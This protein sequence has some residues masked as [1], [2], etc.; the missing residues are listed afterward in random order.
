MKIIEYNHSFAKEVAKMWN[1]SNSSWGN[2]GSLQTEQDIITKE[3]SSG[4]IKLYL[5]VDNN[6]VVGYCSFSEYQQDEGA[7][8][9][10][11]LNVRP[12][13]H[14]KKVGKALILKVLED[15]I[16]ST[17]PRFDLYT[18]SGNIK[19]MP[20]YKKCGFFWEKDNQRVHLMNFIP[21]LYQTE[22]LAKHLNDIDWYTDSKRM[23]DMNQDGLEEH[24]F[25][26]YRYDFENEKT[27]L[28]MEF[29]RYGRGLRMIETPD[30][31]I[32]MSIPQKELVY[33]KS[34]Q[35]EFQIVN[36]TNQPLDITIEPTSNKNITFEGKKT[37]SVINEETVSMEFFVGEIDKPI[38]K[39]KT[40]PVVEANVLINGKKA[41]FKLG[42]EPKCPLEAK[43]II[44]KYNH[45][46]IDEY[47][48][49][50]DLENNLDHAETFTIT[51]PSTIATF[52]DSVTVTLESK[53]KR[54]VEIIYSVEEFGIYKEKAIITFANESIEKELST[55]IKGT[56]S[57]FHGLLE[58]QA[59]LVS[60]NYALQ[61]NLHSHNIR[62]DNSW[63]V[64]GASVFL[65][66]KIGLP[67]SLEFSNTKPLIS[68]PSLNEMTI[69][70]ES[71]AF[72]AVK[73]ILYVKNDY[74]IVTINYK[75]VNEGKQKTLA[76][77]I[78]IWNRMR[79]TY[80]P[81]DGQLLKLDYDGADLSSIYNDKL[82]E[83][84][85]YNHKHNYGLIWHKN[86]VVEIAGWS[87]QAVKEGIVL[88]KGECYKTENFTLSYVHPNLKNFREFIGYY[89]EKDETSFMDINANDGNPFTKE[90]VNISLSNKRKCQLEGTITVDGQTKD[91]TESLRVSPGLK[92]AVIDLKDKQVTYQKM[93]FKLSG[94][95]TQI[96]SDDSLTID[97]GVLSFSVSD[98]YSDAIYSLQ[99][100]SHE[101]LDSNYPTPKE[102]VWWGT[103]IGGLN[104]RVFGVQDN[105]V[106]QEK[107]KSSFVTLTDNFNN[108]WS[109]IKTS[110]VF[111][112]EINLKGFT[113]DTYTLTLPG[114]EL[115]YTFT[116]I[117]N[118]T[119][120][121]QNKGYERFITLQ[122]DDDKTKV[123]FTKDNTTYKCGDIAVEDRFKKHIAL[124]STRNHKLN[125]YNKKNELLMDSQTGYTICFSVHWHEI[126]DQ[127]SKLFS[128][129]FIFFTKESID[130]KA[131]IDLENI[132]F[133][134]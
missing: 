49:Y 109:G 29:E 100:D 69:T 37:V 73:V 19:A 119:G 56:S 117:K 77:K 84:W 113:F 111:E 13:Y 63:D 90:A 123:S 28:S 62:V 108:Q 52:K 70:Y 112:K 103:F 129:D 127:E 130:K 133:E 66:P 61:Y 101:W 27:K 18:W 106:L 104:F 94:D 76:L 21:Y 97:N 38:L 96:K 8:Y 47:K 59:F 121:H 64:Q 23:I 89:N 41:V 81:F 36:K 134:V 20:L 102:R 12:D 43:L 31:K 74:G 54:S 6:E 98:T 50:L 48:A 25:D 82:D 83:N 120:K 118:N 45:N 132:T 15:A 39:S 91:I 24:G 65:P 58:H 10:P 22:A 107:R 95:V 51:L 60:G 14:G 126:P 11:L 68:F 128:G 114:V 4:N 93:L 72:E 80:V 78:P 122:A 7:S 131:F 33:N 86:S 55:I 92:E 125:I 26:Y 71:Q 116:H 110:V 67:Y 99:F 42:I 17:W 53:E 5:A 2:D 34:Y 30:Y 40:H 9:L 35:T 85:I 115:L 105:A 32:I 3:S 79:D 44:T 124:C 46:L 88:G 16:H 75:L 57:S 1:M 87:L